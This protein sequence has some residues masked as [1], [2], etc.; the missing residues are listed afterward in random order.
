MLMTYTNPVFVDV[1]NKKKPSL[2]QKG[3]VH[4]KLSC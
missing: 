4:Q 1:D 3:L 2:E